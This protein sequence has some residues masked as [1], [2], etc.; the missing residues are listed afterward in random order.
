[1]RGKSTKKFV[2]QLRELQDVLGASQDGLVAERRLRELADRHG[3]PAAAFAAGVVAERQRELA[4]E[5]RARLPKLRR[6]V[7]RAGRKAWA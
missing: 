2:S 5:K 4:H 3:H 1:M 7:E 6:R